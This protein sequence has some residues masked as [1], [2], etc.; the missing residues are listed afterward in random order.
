MRNFSTLLRENPGCAYQKD[1]PKTSA[2]FKKKNVKTRFCLNT[3][4]LMLRQ[5]FIVPLFQGGLDSS[6]KM[7]LPLQMFCDHVNDTS[8]RLW[9][10]VQ[11]EL[12]LP[13]RQF[14]RQDVGTSVR[15]L[16][17]LSGCLIVSGGARVLP[18]RDKGPWCRPYNRQHPL[19]NLNQVYYFSSTL[20][21]RFHN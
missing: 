20:Q 1:L 18:P 4:K 12:F 9:T 14:L 10:Y 16:E 11:D 5:C 15:H 8:W 13:M 21:A 17:V 3:Q 7:A 2:K 19:L 6:E